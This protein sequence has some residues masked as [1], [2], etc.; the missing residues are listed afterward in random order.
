MLKG[1]ALLILG[2]ALGFVSQENDRRHEHANLVTIA[3]MTDELEHTS[4]QL[5]ISCNAQPRVLRGLM[6]FTPAGTDL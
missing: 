1:A 6:R 2:I 4:A 3:K 5:R